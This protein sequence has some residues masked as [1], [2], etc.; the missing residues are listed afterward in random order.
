MLLYGLGMTKHESGLAPDGYLDS[1]N[2]AAIIF[3]MVEPTVY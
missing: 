3:Q 1:N 2:Q